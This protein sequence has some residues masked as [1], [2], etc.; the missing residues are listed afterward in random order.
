MDQQVYASTVTD[1]QELTMQPCGDSSSSPGLG[2]WQYYSSKGAR[3][4]RYLAECGSFD[5][6]SFYLLENSG[7]DESLSY[8]FARMSIREYLNGLVL[9]W[10][11][12]PSSKFVMIQD[13]A[14]MKSILGRC[15]RLAL[16]TEL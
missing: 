14:P 9:R 5:T 4:E 1:L 12:T 6:T 10:M 8:T 13:T 11:L 16:V 15:R 2:L 7:K 3:R